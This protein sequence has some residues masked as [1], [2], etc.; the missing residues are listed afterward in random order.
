MEAPWL[1]ANPQGIVILH[2]AENSFLHDEMGD[3][4][5]EMAVLPIDHLTYNTGPCGSRRISRAAA[6][7]LA[8]EFQWRVSITQ[9]NIFITPGVAGD[10][11]ALT[12]AT[13]NEGDGDGILVRQPYYNNFNIDT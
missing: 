1:S 4:I 3:F 7:F 2:L 13:C 11:D 10:I 12:F 8:Q 6:T 5:K 9:D